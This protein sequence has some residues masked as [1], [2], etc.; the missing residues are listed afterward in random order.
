[1]PKIVGEQIHPTIVNQIKKRQEMYGMG[2]DSNRT[3]ESHAYLN[4]RT[5]WVK[6]ASGIKVTTDRLKGEGLKE[7]FTWDGLAKYAVLFGGLARL[8]NNELKQRG[9]FEG[10]NNIYDYYDGAY[11]VN[12]SFTSNDQVGEF[13]LVPMPGIESVDV[14]CLNRGSTK[15]ATVKIK[16]YSPEQFKIIDMLYLR[17]G[18]TVFI[19]WGWAPYITNKGSLFSEYSTMIDQGEWGFFD[20]KWKKST[21]QGFLRAIENFR[22]S[23]QGNYD[24][25]LCKVTNFSWDFKT[26]GS[27]DITLE[28]MSLGDLIESLKTNITPNSEL[29]DY[30]KESYKLFDD[31]SP[32]KDATIGPSPIDNWIS[33]YF[34]INK[35]LLS[36]NTSTKQYWKTRDITCTID[37]QY[38]NIFGVF[39]DAT[40][41]PNKTVKISNSENVWLFDLDNRVK[42]LESDGYQYKDIDGDDLEDINEV[43]AWYTTKPKMDLSLLS[44]NPLTTIDREI[45]GLVNGAFGYDSD[46][47]LQPTIYKTIVYDTT[48]VVK[49]QGQKDMCYLHWNTGEDDEDLIND[50]G[51][52]IRFGHLL[53]IINTKIVPLIKSSKKPII[54][55]DTD[56]WAN[57]M[58]LFP[59]QVSLDP[60]VCIV[61]SGENEQISKKVYYN[62]L[63]DW[64]NV[65]KGYAWTMNIY[66]NCNKI[67]ELIKNNMND[68]GDL[69]L[70]TFLENICTELNKALGGVNN[71]EPI[72]DE[73]DNIIKII[74]GS[75]STPRKPEYSLELFGYN[76]NN[77]NQTSTVSNFV[78]DFSIKTEITNDFATMA[79]VGATA[80]GYTKGTENTMFSKW[81]KG[82]VDMFKDELIPSDPKSQGETPDELYTSEFW[83]MR[84]SAYGLS[85]PMDVEYD[86][87]TED[88]PNI[89]DDVCDKNISIVTEFY[90]F[91]QSKIQEKSDE[92]EKNTY[93]SPTNGFIPISLSF[94]MDGISGI[95]IYNEINVNTRFLPQNYPDNLRFI[96]KGVDQSISKND[97]TSKIETVVITN[98]EDK[99]GNPPFT[100]EEIKGIIDD[101]IANASTSGSGSEP[102]SST[103][104]NS[105]SNSPNP[106]QQG[107]GEYNNPTL[108]ENKKS[109]TNSLLERYTKESA[110]EIF[111][112][113][114]SKPGL[115][116]GYTYRIAE[117]LATK[118]TKKKKF[119]G[120]SKGGNHAY[121]KILRDHLTQL[122]I[123]KPESSTPVATGL[124]LKEAKAKMSE[125]TKK[126]NYG[127]V[128][129]YYVTPEP[130]FSKEPRYHAQI[131]TGNL[132]KN[133]K[134]WSTSTYNNYGA[135][136]VYPSGSPWTIYWFRIKDEYKSST[137]QTSST[138]TTDPKKS[139]TAFNNL[140]F[141]LSKIY[142]LTDDY[143][144]GKKP[145]FEPYKGFD[146]NEQKAAAA[147]AKW[148][149]TDKPSKQISS[150]TNDDK[151]EFEKYFTKLVKQTI[152]DQNNVTFKSDKNKDVKNVT[153]DPDF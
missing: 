114:G 3:P 112:S 32:G 41:L 76:K 131:Y 119:P 54:K 79:T 7:G 43:G 120:T 5:A 61:K 116:G 104:P 126:S 106:E 40:N 121:S 17:I 89:L 91:C 42:E 64:K 74:D 22:I 123:Y 28:L 46:S 66:L 153:I 141:M 105:P 38:I 134:K 151:K 103:S 97:W 142:K 57:K 68:K 140:T 124:S 62:T 95:K 82:L 108:P 94:T 128:A 9:S 52:Y 110:R 19:E 13:G 29:I 33:A 73:V 86:V 26:D 144:N 10:K 50:M 100:Y 84:Y 4:S 93:G 85:I 129:I 122:E 55:I 135:E 96:I 14:K 23:K 152:G 125:I 1:M 139:A 99:N 16:C 21:H 25:L 67:N 44:A 115:C 34:F 88:T 98:N 146:D 113:L 15:K 145:L 31:G 107:S 8:D 6:M 71:L 11:N 45:G 133:S 81:N 30:I 102:S 149:N 78:R 117:K 53:D 36:E 72:V 80:G 111:A 60:R 59:Y 83:K 75:Y 65:D 143:G 37:G 101:V 118:L 47:Y 27:Y 92:L 2:A 137:T 18:Y 70:F 148:I 24:G 109:E 39:I 35:V 130:K 20:E 51:F 136:F 150:L 147:L 87:S 127:D 63:V 56:Q 58:Y 138:S 48:D 90:K 132:Y 49:N 12:A 69:D 77:P